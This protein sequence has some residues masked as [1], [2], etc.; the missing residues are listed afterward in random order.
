MAVIPDAVKESDLSLELLKHLKREKQG[1]TCDLFALPDYPELILILATDRVSI[2]NF[3][4]PTL[5]EGKGEL[6]TAFI[7]FTL[8]ELLNMYN[9]HLM[10]CGPEI[11]DFIPFPLRFKPELQK[12]GLVVKRLDIIPVECIVRNYLTGGGWKSYKEKGKV[13]GFSLP[14]NL[15]QGDK[16]PFSIFHPTEKS[17]TDDELLPSEVVRK[18]GEWIKNFSLAIN[19]RLTSFAESCGMILVDLKL[20]F[21]CYNGKMHIAD[22][23]IG[24]ESRWWGRDDWEIAMKRGELP[25]HYDKEIYR[26]WG[27]E[28]ETPWGKGINAL[29]PQNPEHLDFVNHLKVPSDVPELA[30]KRSHLLFSTLTAYSLRNFQEELMGIKQDG[31]DPVHCYG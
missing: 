10:G 11:D 23:V 22:E 27:R 20:E 21:G 4:L 31:M 14:W 1:K 9:H 6:R 2:F 13:A 30:V 7:V 18:Y 19:N 29:D 5:M 12:R 28:V 25:S 15:R 24:F 26:Q 17:E 8:T 3:V 16:L